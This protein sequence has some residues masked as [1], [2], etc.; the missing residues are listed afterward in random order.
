MSQ[1]TSNIQR[2]DKGGS[3]YLEQTSLARASAWTLCWASL[4]EILRGEFRRG[5]RSQ[6][7]TTCTEVAQGI[8]TGSMI[9]RSS[10]TCLQFIDPRQAV[11]SN[12][13]SI[14]LQTCGVHTRERLRTIGKTAAGV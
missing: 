6:S 9:K 1:Y 7:S 12:A 14:Y 10:S 11:R 13:D 8:Y 5:G 4:P 3:A 2:L